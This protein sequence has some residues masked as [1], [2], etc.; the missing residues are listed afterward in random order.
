MKVQGHNDHRY[1]GFN[2]NDASHIFLSHIFLLANP[3]QENVGQ[4]NK[5]GLFPQSSAAG[6]ND[7]RS[8]KKYILASGGRGV[9][10]SGKLDEL[11]A[12]EG[13]QKAK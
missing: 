11:L 7:D 10:V 9:V 6:R 13:R 4:E 2:W 8:H 3:K 12:K 5:G 1:P